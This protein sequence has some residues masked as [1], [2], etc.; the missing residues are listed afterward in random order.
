MSGRK[1]TL[2]IKA[3]HLFSSER[4]ELPCP[5]WGFGTVACNLKRGGKGLGIVVLA[6]EP[7]KD[8]CIPGKGGKQEG[9]AAVILYERSIG[10]IWE[11]D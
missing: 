7:K 4:K 8:H 2:L 9:K 10:N 5:N 3:T 1:K 6:R 11:I